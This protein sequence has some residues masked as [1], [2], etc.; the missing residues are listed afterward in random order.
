MDDDVREF[1]NQ[2]GRRVIA[3]DW[4][5]VYGMLAP[6]MRSAVSADEVEEFFEQEYRETLGANEIEGM[7]YPEHPDPEVGGNGFTSAT[8][9]RKPISF[10]GG[11][12][13]PLA[14]EVTDETM[15]FWMN[16]GLSCSDEQM[17]TLGFDTFCDI[18]MAI[19]QTPEGLRVGYWSHGA[20]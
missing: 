8:E 10:A 3:R 20:Y 14:P 19:V 11:K 9:L 18:W 1:G 7:H 12:V 2:L 6:W 13:R 5:A 16:L 17:E 15:R 4:S